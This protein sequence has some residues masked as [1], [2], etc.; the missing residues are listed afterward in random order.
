MSKFG[1]IFMR[2]KL[3][4]ALLLTE[5]LFACEILR[6]GLQLWFRAA[7]TSGNFSKQRILNKIGFCGLASFGGHAGL[8]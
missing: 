2:G 1:S 7:T 8:S 3:P 6:A 5:Y 4:F